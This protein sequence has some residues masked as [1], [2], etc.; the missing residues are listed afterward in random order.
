MSH[1]H[2]FKS[3]TMP[4]LRLLTLAFFSFILPNFLKNTL[5]FICTLHLNG[6][7]G[8]LLEPGMCRPRVRPQVKGRSQGSDF[9]T[10]TI[11][12]KSMIFR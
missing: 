10:L 3:P 8:T 6:Q 2:T 9:S 7:V 12:Q 11:G 5:L 4:R 1:N